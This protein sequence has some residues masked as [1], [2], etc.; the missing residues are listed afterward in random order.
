MLV[1][2][3][4][5]R[6]LARQTV[7]VH[8]LTLAIRSRL[9]LFRRALDVENTSKLVFMLTPRL[10]LIGFRGR[11]ISLDSLE[12]RNTAFLLLVL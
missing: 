4:E 12:R 6:I 7:M 10:I 5:E 1:S 2:S 8:L 9:E 3:L 11:S